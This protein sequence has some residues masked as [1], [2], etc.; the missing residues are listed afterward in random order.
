MSCCN[1]IP[2]NNRLKSV[3]RDHICPGAQ[4][5]VDNFCPPVKDQVGT[6]VERGQSGNRGTLMTNTYIADIRVSGSWGGGERQ[7][8]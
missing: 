6:L 8:W 3:N 1:R 7:I 5:E 2:R 4:L